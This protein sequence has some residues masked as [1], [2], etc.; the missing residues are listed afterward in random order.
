MF[1]AF[2]IFINVCSWFLSMVWVPSVQ[3][4]NFESKFDVFAGCHWGCNYEVGI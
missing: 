3:K 4:V 1:D 2:S